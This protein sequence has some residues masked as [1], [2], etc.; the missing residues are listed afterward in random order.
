MDL[1]D[2]VV[3]QLRE[4]AKLLRSVTDQLAAGEHLRSALTKARDTAVWTGPP[5]TAFCGWL[6]H[7]DRWVREQLA[8]GVAKVA[9]EIERHASDLDDAQRKLNSGVP[10]VSCPAQGPDAADAAPRERVT[11]R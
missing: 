6:E 10:G 11:F 9:E 1:T 4:K 8:T 5:Q 2:D 7:L 3:Q